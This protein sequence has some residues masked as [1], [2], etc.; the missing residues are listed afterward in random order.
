[1]GVT[2]ELMGLAMGQVVVKWNTE[3]DGRVAGIGASAGKD[4][5]GAQRTDRGWWKAGDLDVV[6]LV[7]RANGYLL[8][9]SRRSALTH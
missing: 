2:W 1:V 3:Y 6:W 4:R 5:Y 9:L 7:V 8:C